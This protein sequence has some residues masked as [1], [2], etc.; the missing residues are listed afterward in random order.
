[1]NDPLFNLTRPI[2]TISY[3]YK[4]PRSRP[5]R[6]WPAPAARYAGETTL[7]NSEKWGVPNAYYFSRNGPTIAIRRSIAAYL[8][9]VIPRGNIIGK[10][11]ESI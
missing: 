7:V 10:P 1:M 3:R 4:F 9:F 11:L 8:G 6:T 2:S 5:R